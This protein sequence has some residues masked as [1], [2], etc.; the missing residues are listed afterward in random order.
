[1]GRIEICEAWIAYCS[2]AACRNWCPFARRRIP[3]ERT[4][5]TTRISASN[6][7]C[8]DEIAPQEMTL[9]SLDDCVSRWNIGI[10]NR[11]DRRGFRSACVWLTLLRIYRRSDLK[12]SRRRGCANYFAK[13]PFGLR[14]IAIFRIVG[15]NRRL[16]ATE[17]RCAS[18][19]AHSSGC[20]SRAVP[21]GYPHGAEF[22]AD[23]FRSRRSA[24]FPG[25]VIRASQ[26]LPRS[27]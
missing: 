25:V 14:G 12:V 8:R 22:A 21:R 27:A 16:C 13:N 1:M 11:D 3:Q 20:W 10:T 19:A 17:N 15:S 2:E 5:Y 24:V 4:L 6:W 18:S 7:A 26:R 9:T 23:D